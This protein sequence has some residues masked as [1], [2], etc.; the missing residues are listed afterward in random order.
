MASFAQFAKKLI[1]TD[2]IKKNE[3]N[4][5]KDVTQLCL[6]EDSIILLRPFQGKKITKRIE[7]ALD[8]HDPNLYYKIYDTAGMSYLHVYKREERGG[9]ELVRFFMA[10]HSEGNIY[11]ETK[12]MKS[13]SSDTRKES[14][15]T[16]KKCFDKL[17]SLVER[18]NKLLD[19]ANALVDDAKA[20]GLEY[21]FDI[22]CRGSKNEALRTNQ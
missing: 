3:E 9:T 6:L 16:L 19:D 12:F 11:D 7:T 2:E 13:N 5:N 1:L 22:I 8:K 4:L 10:Y 15:E 20:V 17:P 21:D 14:I 18:Y